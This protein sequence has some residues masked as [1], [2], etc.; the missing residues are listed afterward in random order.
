M[1]GLGGGFKYLLF[2]P[3]PGEDFQFDQYFSK[4]LVQPPTRCREMVISPTIAQ[5]KLWFVIQLKPLFGGTPGQ[6]KS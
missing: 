6:A 1:D 5:V 3:L 4:G 2:S